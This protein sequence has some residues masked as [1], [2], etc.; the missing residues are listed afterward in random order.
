LLFTSGIEIAFI[1]A[2]PNQ[3]FPYYL[4]RHASRLSASMDLPPPN[5]GR[6]FL[7]LM[8]LPKDGRETILD[9]T[10]YGQ[11]FELLVTRFLKPLRDEIVKGFEIGDEELSKV[12][13]WPIEI[14]SMRMGFDDALAFALQTEDYELFEDGLSES[15][16]A[17]HYFLFFT[18][19]NEFVCKAVSNP[20]RDPRF[21]NWVRVINRSYGLE[22][23]PPRRLVYDAVGQGAV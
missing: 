20:V 13:S 22:L 15:M 2:M 18:D 17:D 12:T 6:T 3:S 21:E 16:D 7:R 1:L 8:R 19:S 4:E 23:N 5:S 11:K 10:T 9:L 14:S